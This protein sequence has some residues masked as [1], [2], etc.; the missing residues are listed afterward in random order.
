MTIALY[1]IVDFHTS[2]KTHLRPTYFSFF[3]YGAIALVQNG[4]NNWPVTKS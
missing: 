1:A 2:R 4:G 3:R